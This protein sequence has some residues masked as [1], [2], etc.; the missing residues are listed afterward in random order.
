MDL[1][2]HGE[3]RTLHHDSLTV[4]ERLGVLGV[5]QRRVAIERNRRGAPRPRDEITWVSEGDVIE[6]VSFVGGG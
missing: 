1:T 4:T 3:A 2:I 5:G 6:V